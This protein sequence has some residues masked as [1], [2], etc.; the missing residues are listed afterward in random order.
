MGLTRRKFLKTAGLTAGAVGIGLSGFDFTAWAEVQE[1][2]EVVKRPSLCNVCASHCGMWIHVKN[3]RIWKVTGHEENGRSQGRL[4]PRAHGGI[5]WVY[6]PYRLKQPI[7]IEDDGSV[8]PIGWN[9]ALDEIAEKLT[10]IL[11]EEGPEKVFYAH[12]PRR[13]GV[14]MAIGLCML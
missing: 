11:E 13:T 10:E 2:S 12:N 8:R 7:K 9:Q 6:D 1:D 3:E 5:D 4:C 14:F